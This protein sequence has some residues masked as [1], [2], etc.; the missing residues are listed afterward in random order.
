MYDFYRGKK[1]SEKQIWIE[2]YDRVPV[3]EHGVEYPTKETITAKDGEGNKLELQWDLLRQH[4]VY[5]DVPD[6]YD[7]N[8]TFEIIAEFKGS[9]YEASSG[10]TVPISGVGWA[11]WSGPSFAETEKK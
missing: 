3:P 2:Y 11:D 7:D 1:E 6:P 9:F 10:T 8:I 4:P 5:Y